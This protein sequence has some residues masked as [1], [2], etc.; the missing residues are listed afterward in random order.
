MLATMVGK[1]LLAVTM[2]ST[3]GVG[4]QAPVFNGDFP[5]PAVV[6]VGST[7]WAYGTG[8]AG[9][10]LQVIQ[11]P[12]LQTWS[13]PTDPLPSLPA[14]ASP[15]HTWAPGVLRIGQT[16]VMYYT[17]RDAAAGRQCI[18]VATSST[19]AGPFSD[20]S[21][22]PL[23]C[24]LADGGSIDPNPYVDPAG[25]LYL[26]WKSDDNALGRPTHLWGQR[27]TA[28]GAALVG[29]PSLLLTESAAWQ[30]PTVE[31]PTVV[32]HGSRY[33]L[34]YGANNYDTATSGIGY[35]TSSAL[36]GSYANRSGSQ[37][38]LATRGNA[39][40]PQGPNVFMDTSGHLRMAFAAW[41]GSV[42]YENGGVRSMWDATLT[43]TSSG[44]PTVA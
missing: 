37:P 23:V 26:L 11:S 17:V 20:T 3:P 21:T 24:Q 41:Y 34:F 25:S 31:G 44:Q 36:L 12:D 18:S 29:A 9:R 10:N 1:V 32:A 30:A 5:D 8:S 14:W 16:F 7:Y 35:A 4:F 22:G 27:L 19:P 43:F 38:W 39:Q 15:G 42:G 28:T 33:Y 6:V 13:A 40:G 2:L